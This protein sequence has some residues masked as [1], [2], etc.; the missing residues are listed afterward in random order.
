VVCDID[1][2][3]CTTPTNV[4]Y[5]R[6]ETLASCRPILPAVHRVQNAIANGVRFLFVTGRGQHLNDLTVR[7]LKDWLGVDQVDVR[8]RPGD[9]TWDA[10]HAHK[11]RHN[12][13]AIL[14]IG[15]R[16]EDAKAAAAAGVPFMHADA[17]W[18]GQSAPVHPGA[19]HLLAGV[20]L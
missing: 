15:D 2:T 1:G 13:G 11:V 5:A 7:Q 20:R 19:V 4:D 6:G 14:S 12:E 10:Y 9:F 16:M 8:M 3:L 17:W 18:R